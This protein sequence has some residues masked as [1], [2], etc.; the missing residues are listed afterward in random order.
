MERLE[1]GTFAL[2]AGA[3]HWIIGRPGE[4]VAEMRARHEADA[5]PMAVDDRAV[6]WVVKE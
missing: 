4:T 1:Q 2:F 3:C 6:C 5:G